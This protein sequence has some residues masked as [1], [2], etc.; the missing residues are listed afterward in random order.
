LRAMLLAG[1]FPQ[2]HSL[3]GL[4]RQRGAFV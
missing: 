4:R 1:L 3:C 2:S